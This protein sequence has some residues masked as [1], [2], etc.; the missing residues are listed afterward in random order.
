VWLGALL[1]AVCFDAGKQLF[2]IYVGRS[3]TVSSFGAASSLVALVFWIYYTSQI[4][5][6]GAEFTRAHA[7]RAGRCVH[8]SRHSV[9]IDRGS[10]PSLPA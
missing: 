7:E 8:A 2:G 9:V 1:T 6:F 5:F 3:S 4:V 10:C